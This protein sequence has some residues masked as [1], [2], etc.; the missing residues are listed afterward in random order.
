VKYRGDWEI[1]CIGQGFLT[2]QIDNKPSQI[3]ME[4]N[5]YTKLVMGWCH[6]K[7]ENDIVWI[8]DNA[9][10]LIEYCKIERHKIIKL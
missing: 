2:L 4:K 9:G 10:D 6:V 7:F 5:V 3:S 8:Y 1:I